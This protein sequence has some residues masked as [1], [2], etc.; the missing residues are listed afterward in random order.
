MPWFSKNKQ[1]NK[2]RQ[3][4]L[5]LSYSILYLW[6]E[7]RLCLC[8]CLGGCSGS[9]SCDYLVTVFQWS[10]LRSKL[11]FLS[12]SHWPCSLSS[13]G[14]QPGLPL[15]SLLYTL[16][17]C[18]FWILHK[19][20]MTTL[21]YQT[22]THRKASYTVI[23]VMKIQLVLLQRHTLSPANGLAPTLSP[24]F[25]VFYLCLQIFNCL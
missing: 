4:P 6:P 13:C 17:L 5:A 25:I 14:R 10:S 2:A 12:T 16:M 19:P 22:H 9:L 7:R 8:L 11:F 3:L 1:I 24:Q 15:P 23:L 18:I 21:C 20:L